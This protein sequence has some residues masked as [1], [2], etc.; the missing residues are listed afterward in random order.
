MN[1]YKIVKKSLE[2]IKFHPQAYFSMDIIL[3]GSNRQFENK[4]IRYG[5]WMYDEVWKIWG[6]GTL[7]IWNTDIKIVNICYKIYDYIFCD[8][9]YKLVIKKNRFDL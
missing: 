5:V 9:F 2:I 3:S 6:I 4:D 1:N 7:H 8:Y